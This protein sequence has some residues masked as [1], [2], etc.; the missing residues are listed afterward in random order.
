MS[1]STSGP[2]ETILRKEDTVDPVAGN[3]NTQGYAIKSR[4]IN[5]SSNEEW[6]CTDASTGA[7]LW[8]LTTGG[9]GDV[10]GPASAVDNRIAVFDSTT[11]KLI[12]DNTGFTITGGSRIIGNTAGSEL[13]LKETGTG[14]TGF[15]TWGYFWVRN[16]APTS[17]VFTNDT[18]V[19]ETLARFVGNSPTQTYVPVGYDSSGEGRLQ[20]SLLKY[21]SGEL[22]LGDSTGS[23]RMNE[24]A[25]GPTF[26]AGDGFIWMKTGASATE[27]WFTDDTGA[28]SNIGG[29]VVGPGTV[30][31]RYVCLWDGTSGKLIK[32][33]LDMSY[34]GL[35][36]Q[37]LSLAGGAADC[38]IY[39]RGTGPT[40]S[41]NYGKF[42]V[43]SG[44]PNVAMFTD[45]AGTETQ[46]GR[47]TPTT[48]ASNEL[49]D[50]DATEVVIGG[51]YLDGSTGGTF[52]WEILG[53]YN[54]NGGTGVQDLDVY[55]YDR[56]PDGT[57]VAG[58]LRSTLSID[59]LDTLDRVS[60]TLTASG[61]P[62][63]DTDTIFNTGRL[64]E[65][66]A[67]LDAGGGVDTAKV[68]SVRFI[69]S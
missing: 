42:W 2:I 67:K 39:E 44:A 66:R 16:D 62:G 34:G 31:N 13:V 41:A 54:D 40:L 4:W 58:V 22:Y 10:V 47:P 24:R 48:L 23:L 46:L 63:V 14:P 32:A 11:G 9:D 60:Q 65:V 53:T 18:G 8:E 45:G 27:P 25:T 5:T 19:E 61:T 20:T 38:A 6:V 68:L 17:P 3:D 55:L 28:E 36:A 21:N 12:K 7:A 33:A 49:V 56:G 30:G 1:Y 52:T 43:K 64:Y 59:T 37:S 69:E 51:A 50:I 15:A 29:D 26:V 35:G 57:P